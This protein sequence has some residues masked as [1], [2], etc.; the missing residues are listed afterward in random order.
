MPP[1]ILRNIGM[2]KQGYLDREAEKVGAE[3][4]VESEIERVKRLMGMPSQTPKDRAKEAR[5]A[6]KSNRK[7]GKGSYG[8]RK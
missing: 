4:P 7:T 5:G 8:F 1:F 6:R 2:G 3:H